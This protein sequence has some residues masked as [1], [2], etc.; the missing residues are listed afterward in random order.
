MRT[1]TF[2]GTLATTVVLLV[3]AGCGGERAA[4]PVTW[5]DDV[6]GALGSFTDALLAQPVLDSGDPVAAVHGLRGYLDVTSAAVQE[7]LGQLDAVDASPVDGGD[8][9]VDR[10]TGALTEIQAG[11]DAARAGLDDIDTSS[12]ESARAALPAAVAP[13]Q[14]LRGLA[15]PTEG[16]R[17]NDELRVAAEQAPRCQELRTAGNPAE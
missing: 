7:S 2:T 9:Y 5:A 16:L 6:C 8:A 13:L 1:R 17:D 14:E 15:D 10:L 4:D 11:F 3:A 12:A